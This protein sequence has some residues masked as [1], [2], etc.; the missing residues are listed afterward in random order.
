MLLTVQHIEMSFLPSVRP[1]LDAVRLFVR[2][3]VCQTRALWQNE[4]NLSTFLH[5]KNVYP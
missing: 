2:L 1:M 5:Q 3:S 4:R